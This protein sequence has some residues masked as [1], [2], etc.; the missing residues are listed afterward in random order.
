[1]DEEHF[2]SVGEYKAKIFKAGLTV[3][4]DAGGLF[5]FRSEQDRW[6]NGNPTARVPTI[7]T[8]KLSKLP[9]RFAL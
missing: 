5:R 8:T 6:L 9:A 3:A 1:L 7:S 4:H 2:V